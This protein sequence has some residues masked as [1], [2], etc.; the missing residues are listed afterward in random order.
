[1]KVLIT[2]AGGQLGRALCAAAPSGFAVTALDG[3][4]RLVP[5][6]T[7]LAE[8][9]VIRCPWEEFRDDDA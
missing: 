8:R 6:D 2:G 5:K 9:V 4:G 1:M 3:R 7:H